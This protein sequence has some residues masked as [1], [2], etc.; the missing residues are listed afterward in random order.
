MIPS[1]LAFH[2]LWKRDA[3]PLRF[4]QPPPDTDDPLLTQSSSE[5]GMG[6]LWLLKSSSTMCF[7]SAG[8]DLC[9]RSL[10]CARAGRHF[11]QPGSSRCGPCLRPLVEDSYGRC[12]VRRRHGHP[13]GKTF[14][15]EGSSSAEIWVA[16]VMQSGSHYLTSFTFQQQT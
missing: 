12:I 2:L 10:D 16:T 3:D 7:A 6:K 4:R 1:F 8:S 15:A 11:C 5:G 14:E 9:P 13:S